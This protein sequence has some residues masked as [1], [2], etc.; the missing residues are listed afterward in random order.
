[1]YNKNQ[2]IQTAEGFQCPPLLKNECSE[3]VEVCWQE[4]CIGDQAWGRKR[5]K[6]AFGLY[7]YRYECWSIVGIQYEEK[8]P[9]SVV[10]YWRYATPLPDEEGPEVS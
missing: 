4:S 8:V 6:R 10:E 9:Q 2:W 1:M 5:R 3:I 7:N